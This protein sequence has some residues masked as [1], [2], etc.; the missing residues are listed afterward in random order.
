MHLYV[1]PLAPVRCNLSLASAVA[2]RASAPSQK[3][4]EVVSSI[5]DQASQLRVRAQPSEHRLDDYPIDSAVDPGQMPEAWGYD[6]ADVRRRVGGCVGTSRLDPAPIC[7]VQRQTDQR[8][9]NHI[10]IRGGETL[11][12][13][14]AIERLWMVVNWARH[15][16]PPGQHPR[17]WLTLAFTGKRYHE[18][19]AGARSITR[20]SAAARR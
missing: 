4:L 18:R 17:R 11:L 9:R 3:C 16:N 2:V 14:R 13:S 20:L 10:W 1:R 5:L 7:F 19:A 12:G 15:D 6:S 8:V